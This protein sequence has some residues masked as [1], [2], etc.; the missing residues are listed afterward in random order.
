MD[1]ASIP[2][3]TIVSQKLNDGQMRENLTKAM[4]TL[5]GNRLNVIENK[6]ED[7]QG[8]RDRARQVKNNALMSLQ[9]RIEEFEK[10]ATKNGI[11]VH[12]ASTDK[13]ACEIIYQ[14]MKDNNV[15]KVLKGKSMASEEIGL[16]HYLK[17]KG[18]KAEESDLGELILQLNDDEPPVHIVAPA[19]HRN[20]YEVGQIF[21]DKLNA[22]LESDIEK[23]NSIARGHLREQFQHLKMG[24]SGVNFAI[25]KEGAIWLVENEGNGR[26]C[27]T[28]P[29]IH[30]AICGIEK[31]VETF[32]DAATLVHLLTPSATGQFIPTYN[33]IITGPRQEGDKDGPC[34][35]HIVIF[36]HNR[37]SMLQ[38]KDFYEALRC[39]RCGACMNFCPVYDKIGGHSYRTTYPGPIGEVISPN[40]FGL[41]VTGDV[42][43]FCSQCGRCSEVCPEKIPLADLIRELRSYKVGQGEG[44]ITGSQNVKPSSSEQI[45]FKLFA[46]AATNGTIWKQAFAQAHIVNPLVKAFAPALPVAKDWDAYKQLPDV[47]GNF[48]KKVQK[49]EGVKYE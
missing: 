45:A 4:H 35:M 39:I 26:M 29:D 15:D 48:Y 36:D 47:S 7:W 25:S 14:I 2:H 8:L 3:K 12:F 16:N 28:T 11:Q 37:S 9:E 43:S 41:D 17:E 40:L 38:H 6:F 30:V 22:P 10:N 44:Q 32:E 19:I 49:I 24:I 5:Q 1:L 27:T 18:L 31:I 42:L 20:R 21:H 46:K 33:N 34:Q 23:L 13:D